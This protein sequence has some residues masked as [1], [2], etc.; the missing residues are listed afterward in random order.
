MNGVEDYD[1]DLDRQGEASLSHKR[2]IT[3]VR[4]FRATERPM[5]DATGTP[6]GLPVA[7]PNDLPVAR[8]RDWLRAY[9]DSAAAGVEPIAP[10]SDRAAI[11][12]GE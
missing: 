3:S 9:A 6:L 12:A 10:A 5:G 7:S 1:T 2:T 11:S 4:D 8:L